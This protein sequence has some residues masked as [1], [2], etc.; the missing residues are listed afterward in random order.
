[1]SSYLSVHLY[2]IWTS[3]QDASEI[4]DSKEVEFFW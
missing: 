4:Q 2:D 3:K 1:M